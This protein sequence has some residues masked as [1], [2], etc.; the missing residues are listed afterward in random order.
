[1]RIASAAGALLFFGAALV[2]SSS[3]A[4]FLAAVPAVAILLLSRFGWKKGAALLLAGG[5]PVLAIL[6]YRA[7]ARFTEPDVYNYA[8]LVLWE[9]AGKIFLSNPFGVGLGG[10]KYLWFSTQGPIEG[11]FMRYGRYA[12]TAHS[13]F[14]E[15]LSGLGVAG[16]VLFVLVLFIPLFAVWRG[17]GR[18]EEGRR[19]AVAGATCGLLVSGLHAAVDFN[20]HE[21]GLV[22]LDAILLGAVMASLPE[23]ISGFRVAVPRWCR[24]LGVGVAV[25]LFGVSAATLAGKVAHAVGERSFRAGNTAG[26]ER[27]YGIAMTAD[28]FCDA[29]P[30]AM[31]ALFR[32][33]YLAEK[34]TGDS[35]GT[36]ARDYLAE[37]GG[38]GPSVDSD[39]FPENGPA[40]RS[41]GRDVL[42]V[43]KPGGSRRRH[44]G[45]GQGA[46]DQPVQR[47]CV[48]EA[49]ES[50]GPVRARG[51]SRGRP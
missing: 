48:V 20:F 38:Q 34:E 40:H 37:T 2:L 41:P 39:G 49:G 35:G 9:A 1:V 23:A 10:Y 42:P 16:F 11:A 15:V 3:R 43:G 46:G 7:A 8:R 31:G 22:V 30:D 4:I 50:P 13:E 21:I 29:Y 44:P 26:A 45:G 36:R 12:S 18:L 17:F 33:M 25:I 47:Q 14:L 6:G 24:I 32:R 27:M 28:P 51:G 5:L 19:W